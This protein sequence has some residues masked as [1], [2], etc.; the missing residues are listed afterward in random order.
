VRLIS[1]SAEEGEG[2]VANEFADRL[3]RGETELVSGRDLARA[4][5]ELPENG[6]LVA[7]VESWDLLAGLPKPE[8]GRLL[9][10]VRESGAA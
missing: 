3:G 6:A 5:A 7:T 1:S 2:G 9:I 10:A 8:P 4:V